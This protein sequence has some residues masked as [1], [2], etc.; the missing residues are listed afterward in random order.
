MVINERREIQRPWIGTN[1]DTPNQAFVFKIINDKPLSQEQKV[2]TNLIPQPCDPK[3]TRGWTFD[4]T[5]PGRSETT[6]QTVIMKGKHTWT[7]WGIEVLTALWQN[8]NKRWYLWKLRGC[9]STRP[10]CNAIR[11]WVNVGG[12]AISKGLM[13]FWSKQKSTV[14][15]FSVLMT[16]WS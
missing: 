2:Y 10:L 12:H 6:E 3:N 1:N 16:G 13:F 4:R 11:V 9:R 5:K 7:D 14:K 8:T 15:I